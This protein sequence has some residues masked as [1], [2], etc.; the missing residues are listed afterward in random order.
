MT[1]NN[2]YKYATFGSG[3]FWCSEAVFEDV[4]GVINVVSG[5]SGGKVINPSYKEV[6]TGRT[7]HAEVVQI[8][9]DPGVVSYQAL[10]NIFFKT[11]DPTSLNR[12]GADVGTQYRSVIFYHDENQEKL[13]EETIKRLNN[14]GVYDNKIVTQVEP[15]KNF[16]MA[17]EYHQDYYNKHPE[18]GYCSVVISPKLKKLKEDFSDMLKK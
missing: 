17:D 5:Y 12:Q 3:C 14:S 9:Y 15:F 10:L 4:K 6:C 11:H 13:A 18:Y 16:Y 7:G 8:K 1:E 2:E